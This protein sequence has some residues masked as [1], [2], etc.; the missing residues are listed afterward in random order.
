MPIEVRELQIRSRV[1]S[2]ARS[3]SAR[4]AGEE[5][6]PVG[7]RQLERLRESVLAECRALVAA[8]LRERLER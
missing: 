8:A 2:S 4:G 7:E 1:E 3:S 6:D 5:L